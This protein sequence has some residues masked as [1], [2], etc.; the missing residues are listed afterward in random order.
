MTWAREV[1]RVSYEWD[2]ESFDEYGDIIDHDWRAE[3]PGLPTEPNIN[4]VLI[5]DVHR[6]LPGDDFNMSADLESRSWAYVKDGQ[7]P[8]EFDC[9]TKVPQRFHKEF[10]KALA[11]QAAS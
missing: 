4:L 11:E 1:R 3:C 8:D 7:L 2:Y 9:G 6:G 10:A 5:R